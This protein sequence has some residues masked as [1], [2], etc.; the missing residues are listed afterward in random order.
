MFFVTLGVLGCARLA[1]IAEEGGIVGQALSRA[2]Q[3]EVPSPAASDETSEAR[4]PSP[5]AEP[6]D[7]TV[8]ANVARHHFFTLRWNTATRG[9]VTEVHGVVENRNGPMF[10]EVILR[11]A[12]SGPTGQPGTDRVVLRGPF[13]KKAVRPFS[14]RVQVRQPVERV[15]VEVASYEFY[16]PRDR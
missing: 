10:R 7:Q 15:L 8:F 12:A 1:R 4:A 13:D 16:Q 5:R 14:M 2:G 3:D 11:M 6:A 9:G